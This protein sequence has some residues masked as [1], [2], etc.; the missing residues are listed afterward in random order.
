MGRLFRSESSGVALV[1]MSAEEKARGQAVP[2]L[3]GSLKKM[4]SFF[5]IVGQENR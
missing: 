5:V 2:E 3:Y 4:R 1:E